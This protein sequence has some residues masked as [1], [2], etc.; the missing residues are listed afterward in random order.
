[1][2]TKT[3]SASVSSAENS[4]SLGARLATL[5]SSEKSGSITWGDAPDSLLSSVIENVVEA[6][7]LISFGRTSDGGALVLSILDSGEPTKFY[8]ANREDLD[9]KMHDIFELTK[10][11]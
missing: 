10:D 4:S 9:A 5:K 3:R 6:G 11:L 2:N 8:F 1:M 7:S